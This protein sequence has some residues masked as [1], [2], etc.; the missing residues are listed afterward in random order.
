MRLSNFKINL[1][2]SNKLS[3]PVLVDYLRCIRA[4]SFLTIVSRRAFLLLS[5]QLL[6]IKEKFFPESNQH[7][8][9]FSV[10]LATSDWEVRFVVMIHV[11]VSTLFMHDLVIV[12]VVLLN[13]L[14]ADCNRYRWYIINFLC[15]L[16]HC[17][18]LNSDEFSIRVEYLDLLSS[19]S[20]VESLLLRPGRYSI[21][22]VA[23]WCLNHL[24]RN[25]PD[26][27]M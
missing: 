1:F 23:S 26:L 15:V 24:Q 18:C 13:R 8:C 9:P 22:F 11:H 7:S 14:L 19:V 25:A 4:I 27:P 5:K 21:L 6:L 12:I 17:R 20:V 16:Y 2:D 10:E 3:I